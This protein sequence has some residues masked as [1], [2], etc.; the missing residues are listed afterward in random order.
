VTWSLDHLELPGYQ[1][2]Y[3]LTDAAVQRV[4]I[5]FVLRA[6]GHGIGRRARSLRPGR[7]TA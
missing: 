6:S 7:P 1:L 2:D 5:Q 4:K 3:A